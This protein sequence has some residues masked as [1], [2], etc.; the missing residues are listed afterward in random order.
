MRWADT[1]ERVGVREAI[2]QGASH[3]DYDDNDSA[4]SAGSTRGDSEREPHRPRGPMER[5]APQDG[6]PRL[7]GLRTRSVRVGQCGRHGDAEIAGPGQRRVARGQPDP[8]PAVP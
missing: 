6:G 5:V 2:T 4:P 3:V 1:R 7:A 8:G